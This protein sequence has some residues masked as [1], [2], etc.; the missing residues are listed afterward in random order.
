MRIVIELRST[1]ASPA[2]RH[3]AG[4]PSQGERARKE[5]IAG[6]PGRRVEPGR[7]VP[8][9]ALEDEPA[10]K[11]PHHGGD[12]ATRLH[13]PPHLT[14]RGRGMGNKIQRELSESRNETAVRIG[15]PAGI[16]HRKRDRRV[17]R[18]GERDIG[19][20]DVDA[21]DPP[22][23]PALREGVCEAP[24]SATDIEYRSLLGQSHKIGER[25]GEQPRPPPEKPLIRRPVT[26]AIG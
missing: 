4:R 18:S 3:S 22:A 21:G 17:A 23:L 2:S 16:S 15:K 14:H 25:T 12:D 5:P 13:D 1:A 6:A 24:G 11:I 9:Q 19:Q 26:G 20:R 7:G 8:E 10:A